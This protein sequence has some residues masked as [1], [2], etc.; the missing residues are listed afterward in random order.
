L[1]THQGKKPGPARS[2]ERSCT[3]SP[4]K[5]ITFEHSVGGLI[6]APV[7]FLT[8][9]LGW[10]PM[11]RVR[12]ILVGPLDAALANRSREFSSIDLSPRTRVL[13]RVYGCEGMVAAEVN[14]IDV[15]ELARVPRPLNAAADGSSTDVVDHIG[16]MIGGVLTKSIQVGVKSMLPFPFNSI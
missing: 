13:F 1:R 2:L 7:A 10:E 9:G 11:C 5:S 3:R 6:G 4:L 14:D 16:Q 15:L 12:T 8:G